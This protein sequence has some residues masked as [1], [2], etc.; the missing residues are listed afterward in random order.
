MALG[1]ISRRWVCM[2]RKVILAHKGKQH[3]SLGASCDW[4]C[5]AVAPTTVPKA[6][7]DSSCGIS[8]EH[9]ALG[10]DSF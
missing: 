6:I 10:D 1:T 9:P 8:M 2:E 4:S 7:C 3:E 5:R